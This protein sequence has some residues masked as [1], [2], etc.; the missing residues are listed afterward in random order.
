MG[1]GQ[2]VQSEGELLGRQRKEK[3]NRRDMRRS[4]DAGES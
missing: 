2:E 1:H 4:G 3:G